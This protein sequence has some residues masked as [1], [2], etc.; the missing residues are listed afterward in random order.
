MK[1]QYR[2]VHVQEV[3]TQKQVTIDEVV[4]TF[5]TPRVIIELTAEGHESGSIMLD[6]PEGADHFVEGTI[7]DVT[8]SAGESK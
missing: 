4:G 6:L 1:L 5:T 2:V 8:F 3:Q 7:I